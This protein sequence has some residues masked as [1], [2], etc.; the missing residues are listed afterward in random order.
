MP[1]SSGK[2]GKGVSDQDNEAET[3]MSQL[4]EI[5]K[6]IR[7]ISKSLRTAV[8][9]LSEIYAAMPEPEEG[10]REVYLSGKPITDN[11]ESTAGDTG[12]P[13]QYLNSKPA[14]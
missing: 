13:R 8:V 10:Q 12:E 4:D 2:D 5:A 11:P 6:D 14:P 1:G 7:E 3:T 9:I